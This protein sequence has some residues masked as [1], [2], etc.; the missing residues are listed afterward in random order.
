MYAIRS[1]YVYKDVEH[2]LESRDPM[3]LTGRVQVGD[4]GISLRAD[5]LVPLAHHSYNFV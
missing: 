1:Y 2:L 3:V 4:R 5:S